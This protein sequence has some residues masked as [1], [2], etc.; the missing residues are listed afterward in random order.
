[1]PVLCL[2]SQGGILWDL[3]GSFSWEWGQ[4]QGPRLVSCPEM[5]ERGK[6]KRGESKVRKRDK[7]KR[8]EREREKGKREEIRKGEGGKEKK[9]KVEW[10]RE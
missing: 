1:M 8:E 7:G 9:G 2:L 6:V 4:R 3:L 5:R 10:T